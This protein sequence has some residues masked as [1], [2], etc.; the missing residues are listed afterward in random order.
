MQLAAMKNSFCICNSPPDE[1]NADTQ[2]GRAALLWMQERVSNI[3][4]GYVGFANAGGVVGPQSG[5]TV[6]VEFFMVPFMLPGTGVVK[7]TLK[8]QK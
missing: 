1:Q 6:Q 5:P 2:S 4:F 3:P 7:K 8:M